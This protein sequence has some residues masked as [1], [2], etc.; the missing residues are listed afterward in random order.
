MNN[1]N[2]NTGITPR[3]FSPWFSFNLFRV[4]IL[5]LIRPCLGF[6]GASFHPAVKDITQ[7]VYKTKSQWINV[8]SML[9]GNLFSTSPNL[10]PKPYINSNLRPKL[11]PDLGSNSNSVPNLSLSSSKPA[12]L[13]GR[14]TPTTPHL[15]SLDS[16]R[17]RRYVTA[18][19]H[20]NLVRLPSRRK[21]MSEKVASVP[22]MGEIIATVNYNSNKNNNNNNNNNNNIDKN[23]KHKHA[24]TIYE[25]FDNNDNSNK[26]HISSN[27]NNNSSR[28]SSYE[29]NK[30]HVR[31][32]KFSNQTSD[33]GRVDSSGDNIIV[34]R[35]N[36][37]VE[38]DG[39]RTS[40]AVPF[41]PTPLI[42]EDAINEND[43]NKAVVLRGSP[44]DPA[45]QEKSESSLNISKKRSDGSPHKFSGEGPQAEPYESSGEEL[46]EMSQER[47]DET[48]RQ[49]L[50][51]GGSECSADDIYRAKTQNEILKNEED[52]NE[53]D[54]GNTDLRTTLYIGGLFESTEL[55][56]YGRSELHAARLA[57]KHINEK[58]IIPGY[59]LD[60]VFNESS[61]DPGI[62]TDALYNLIYCKPEMIMFIGGA[63]TEVTKTL[64][65]IVP[66][67][68]LILLSY[69]SVSPALSKREVYK[70]LVSVAQADS[71]YNVARMLFIKHFRWDTVATIYEDMEKFSLAMADMSQT[72]EQNNISPKTTEVFL[73]DVA[74]KLGNL[75][76]NDARII[77]GGFRENAA[78]KV[79]CEA[80]RLKLY[81]RRHVWMLNGGYTPEWWRAKNDTNCSEDQLT[82]ALQGYFTVASINALSGSMGMRSIGGLTTEDFIEEY[83]LN[84][85]TAP[86]SP[87]ATNTYDA[88]WT[89]ALTLKSVVEEKING[90]DSDDPK[91]VHLEHFQYES[92]SNLSKQ[93]LET[94]D[95][96]EFVGVSGPVSFDG[97][98]RQS[99]AVIQQYQGGKMQVVALYEPDNESLNFS[100]DACVPIVWRGRRVPYDKNII[101]MKLKAIH[102]TAFYTVCALCIVGVSMAI[103]FL[104]FN[105]Y[106]RSLK[107]IKL[108]SPI[109]NNVA[110]IGCILVYLAL[111]LLGFDEK[112]MRR[113]HYPFVCTTRAFLFAAGFSLAFGA[114][115][116]KTYRVHQIFTRAHSG[117]IRSKLLRDKQLL[118]IIGA[119]LVLDISLI[120]VWIVVDPMHQVK[121][122]LSSQLSTDDEDV[123]YISQL[124]RCQSNHLEKWMGVM[125]AYKGLLLI[126]GVY[127]AWETRNVKIPALNDSRYIGMNVYNVVI[128]STIVVVLSKILSDRPTLSYA[129]QS[130]F[131]FLST[132]G[133]L[134]L[135]FLPKIYAIMT[136]NGNPVITGTGITVQ[137]NIR[138]FDFSDKK[139]LQYRAE[140]QNKVYKR[141]LVALEEE[142]NRLEYLL[143]LP[144][145]SYFRFTDELLALMPED[146]LDSLSTSITGT[147]AASAQRCHS[148][149]D[150]DDVVSYFGETTEDSHPEEDEVDAISERNEGNFQISGLLVT[151]KIKASNFKSNCRKYTK[152]PITRSEQKACL[153]DTN[154][155]TIKYIDEEDEDE[156]DDGVGRRGVRE[157]EEGVGDDDKDDEDK[158]EEEKRF[159]GDNGI[160]ATRMCKRYKLN[161]LKASKA[162]FFA[163]HRSVSMSVD[164]EAEQLP[165]TSSVEILKEPILGSPSIDDGCY[166]ATFSDLRN[167]KAMNQHYRLKKPQRPSLR[168]SKTQPS[169]PLSPDK[170]RYSV[171]KTVRFLVEVEG[172][173]EG[174]D[175][176]DDYYNVNPHCHDY[177][178]EVIADND[179][180]EEYNNKQYRKGRVQYAGSGEDRQGRTFE[181]EKYPGKIYNTVASMKLSSISSPSLQR[182]S[183]TTMM[184][185]L[186]TSGSI[187]S[188]WSNF[189]LNLFKKL[190]QKSWIDDTKNR[191]TKLNNT[192]E[193]LPVQSGPKRTSSSSLSSSSS[194]S[195]DYMLTCSN[196]MVPSKM[197]PLLQKNISEV[198]SPSQS[199]GKLPY[200]SDYSLKEENIKSCPRIEEPPMRISSKKWAKV[201]AKVASKATSRAVVRSSSS[202]F[203]APATTLVAASTIATAT[204]ITTANLASTT[205]NTTFNNSTST[206]AT[207]ATTTSTITTYTNTNNSSIITTDTN[208][209]VQP[210]SSSSVSSSSSTALSSPSSLSSSSP[211]SSSSTTTTITT[212]AATTKTAT[213]TTITTTTS[214]SLSTTTSLTRSATATS[215]S[216]LPSAQAS[217]PSSSSLLISSSSSSTSSRSSSKLSS[218]STLSS[219]CKGQPQPNVETMET[220]PEQELGLP[221]AEGMEKV[222]DNERKIR[223]RKLQQDLTRI[224]REL[225][226]LDD[227]E[228]EVSYV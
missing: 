29:N 150:A 149:S 130:T 212:I 44:K 228:Y 9:K 53:E 178:Y 34:N 52:E 88:I 63:C 186:A 119:L 81:G 117:V 158:T 78:R 70:T 156:E 113:D 49:Y 180:D 66:Y 35:A 215:S 22:K 115:F 58:N 160:G 68:N 194:P 71:S 201:A 203:S 116:S 195:S 191:R 135:M 157:M 2:S 33:S 14:I 79:I 223:I 155:K 36:R 205:T 80:Y 197:K 10:T 226:A 128:M 164:N 47:S 82:E 104:A 132:T 182:G 175:D 105:L 55:H 142:I 161:N 168:R 30:G 140:I 189:R 50:L 114:M 185:S 170:N 83:F 57:I 15:L 136:S 112:T 102:P 6:Y 87:H 59:K 120:S 177:T 38:G 126:F 129:I 127:M 162:R 106:N 19:A 61:C 125:Y 174:G 151:D 37:S 98:D 163:A 76:V 94:I 169:P 153:E 143:E 110:V 64:G 25:N 42:R 16:N 67:W 20:Y 199:R 207:N 74:A 200:V 62:A 65:E 172:C 124:S 73:T 90:S 108:S 137:A 12:V 51:R 196:K 111:M 159:S 86:I 166:S 28:I 221:S 69:A 173:G 209:S 179:D 171:H 60:L 18:D 154:N 23:S 208:T 224:Q 77:I 139:E 184:P 217:A 227:L 13:R 3:L 187:S 32:H 152:N 144:N 123:V 24:Y 48:P 40:D 21:L 225:L 89:I 84:N 193:L 167:D 216:A 99:L 133:T 11:K 54:K 72:F 210:T 27:N 131:I 145:I 43:G 122:N 4:L 202:T 26:S 220:C 134:C 121:T 107:Y 75:K 188:S 7:V 1:S 85:G 97:P 147:A 192:E 31:Q 56:S 218:S 17:D 45:S 41:V 5:L 8:T 101:V 118:F 190:T 214:S 46:G 204:T 39:R 206:A 148:I 95:K 181:K 141:E 91:D 93:F 138:R 176:G 146:G 109:L 222:I 183:S 96:L 100:C 219:S 165:V 211:S 198:S 213:T 92:G 103:F